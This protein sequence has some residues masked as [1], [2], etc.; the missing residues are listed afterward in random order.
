VLAGQPFAAYGILRP[1]PCFHLDPRGSHLLEANSD[2]DGAT[3]PHGS[4]HAQQNEDQRS[5]ARALSIARSAVSVT[6][7]LTSGLT[8]SICARCASITSRADSCFART[9]RTSSVAVRKQILGAVIVSFSLCGGPVDSHPATRNHS[10]GSP[11][12]SSVPETCGGD[13]MDWAMKTRGNL[14]QGCQSISR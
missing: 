11:A 4:T 7:A 14:Y 2:C 9:R 10:R 3:V 6:M 1:S 5:V 8:R 13:G 12:S